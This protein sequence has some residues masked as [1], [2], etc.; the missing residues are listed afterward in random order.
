MS[1]QQPGEWFQS[2]P[3][4]QPQGGQGVGNWAP[5]QGPAVHMPPASPSYAAPEAFNFESETVQKKGAPVGRLAVVG[6]SLALVGGAGFAIKTALANPTG[7]SSPNQAADALFQSLD[8]DDFV[9]VVEL[10]APSEREAYIEPSLDILAEFARLTNNDVGDDVFNEIPFDIEVDGIEYQVTELGPGVSWLEVT[11]GEMTITFNAD[12]VPEWANELGTEFDAP[13]ENE[14]ETVDLR[15]EGM[16]FALVEEDGGWYWS[17]GYTIAENMRA[18]E[19]WSRPSFTGTEMAR[20]A[21]SPEEAVENMVYS[22]TD[23]DL[24]GAFTLLDPEEFGVLYDYSEFFLDDAAGEFSSLRSELDEQGIE[25]SI[26]EMKMKSSEVRGRTV[27]TVETFAASATDGYDRGSIEYR[28]GCILIETSQSEAI[29]TCNQA[30]LWNEMNGGGVSNG[31]NASLADFKS[32]ITVVERDGKWYVSGGPTVLGFYADVL[33]ALTEDD[34]NNFT[35]SLGGI[36]DLIDGNLG[37]LDP[38]ALGSGDDWVTIDDYGDDPAFTDDESF[39][40]DETTETTIGED[41]F[42]D[43]EYEEMNP[44]YIDPSYDFWTDHPDNSVGVFMYSLDIPIAVANLYKDSGFIELAEYA[45]PYDTK[46][47]AAS[48]AEAY[49][50][51]PID[52]GVMG[53]GVVR[54][55]CNDGLVVQYGRWMLYSFES[56]EDTEAMAIDQL[57]H[58]RSIGE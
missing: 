35:E 25:Y 44:V 36:T 26:D 22:L 30:D 45:A 3:P 2:P 19:G 51:E 55:S 4:A 27:V 49:G 42:E 20:G 47:L 5:P 41:Y 21:D 14:T 56:S 15:R 53:E 32:G 1:D 6:L 17:G 18:D 54:Y 43:F 46:R 9:G 7:P 38:F 11:A 57:A 28:D 31:L 13:N 33:A 37:G 8:D 39:L 40:N 58:L 34:W 16:A 48:M 24:R 10:M 23:F 52:A 29:D 50:C 12:E